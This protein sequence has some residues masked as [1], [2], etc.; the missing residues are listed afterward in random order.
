M[1]SFRQY[2]GLIN[3]EGKKQFNSNVLHFEPDEEGCMIVSMT[4]KMI[5]FM[6]KK[7]NEIFRKV[8][9]FP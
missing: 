7:D 4:T 1:T 3:V 6:K 2:N 8:I 5:T 9:N